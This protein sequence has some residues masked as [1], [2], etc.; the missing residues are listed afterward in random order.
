[1]SKSAEFSRAALWELAQAAEHA[2]A[3][4]TDRHGC[5]NER[6]GSLGAIG[7]TY[8]LTMDPYENYDGCWTG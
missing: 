3:P 5:Y 7:A 2:D 4:D 1:M 8:N 6:L